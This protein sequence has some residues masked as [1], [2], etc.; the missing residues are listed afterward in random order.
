MVPCNF[1]IAPD[2]LTG[3]IQFG[4][5]PLRRL[6]CVSAE[7]K[8]T[9]EVH[10][11]MDLSKHMLFQSVRL[12]GAVGIESTSNMETKESQAS[13]GQSIFLSSTDRSRIPNWLQ[14]EKRPVASLRTRPLQFTVSLPL[15]MPY[16]N[17]CFA[18]I[19]P[20]CCLDGQLKLVIQSG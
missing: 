2:G 20:H 4:R 13:S 11:K 19:Q 18:S 5:R 10:G 15:P 7:R 9:P 14:K 1:R 3:N 17:S 8:G 12:V 16:V 6:H